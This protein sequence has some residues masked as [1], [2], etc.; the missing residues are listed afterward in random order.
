MK[1]TAE[2]L[3]NMKRVTKGENSN[4]AIFYDTQYDRFLSVAIVEGAS[5]TTFCNN[6]SY[7]IHLIQSYKSFKK[8]DF[9]DYGLQLIND[10]IN[11]KKIVLE[12]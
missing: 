5:D 3:K 4:W 12:F 2:E 11:K 8:S 9:T 10:Y 7:I 6:I 1:V